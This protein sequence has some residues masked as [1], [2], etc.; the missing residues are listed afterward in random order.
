MTLKFGRKHNQVSWKRWSIFIFPFLSSNS[1]RKPEDFQNILFDLRKLEATIFLQYPAKVHAPWNWST[2]VIFLPDDIYLKCCQPHQDHSLKLTILK[3]SR[4]K[5]MGVG[6]G[7]ETTSR[8]QGWIEQQS[9]VPDPHFPCSPGMFGFEILAQPFIN[10]QNSVPT[11]NFP[12][13]KVK[14]QVTPLVEGV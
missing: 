1:S 2:D 6:E 10:M 4:L 7:N 11:P 12:K 5:K 3:T 9:W 14:L 13:K 8:K